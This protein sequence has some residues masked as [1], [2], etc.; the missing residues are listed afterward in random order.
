[1]LEVADT[2][3]ACPGSGS[4]S[5]YTVLISKGRNFKGPIFPDA[6]GRSFL[7]D[8]R[9]TPLIL[10]WQVVI[11]DLG[12]VVCAFRFHQIPTLLSNS[13]IMRSMSVGNL[14][15]ESTAN[16]C[17]RGTI[18]SWVDPFVVDS[19]TFPTFP[20]ILFQRTWTR[21]WSIHEQWSLRRCYH[22]VRRV[23]LS[24]L[25]HLRPGIRYFRTAERAAGLYICRLINRSWKLQYFRLDYQ[26]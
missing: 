12:F 24:Y 11:W 7:E 9:S 5:M 6:T 1:M 4:D 3:L 16:L 15:A 17:P 2:F 20:T 14:R 21:V 8:S 10:R 18:F 19:T 23:L 26:Q 22:T 13:N 25:V